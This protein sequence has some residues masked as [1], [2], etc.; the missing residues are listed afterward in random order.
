MRKAIVF[1]LLISVLWTVNVPVVEAASIAP[2]VS[3]SAGNTTTEFETDYTVKG[4]LGTAPLLPNST[5]EIIFPSSFSFGSMFVDHPGLT[6]TWSTTGTTVKFKTSQEILGGT[7]LTFEILGVINSN[8]PGTYTIEM[9]STLDAPGTP[10]EFSNPVTIEDAAS[11]GG[12]GELEDVLTCS[13]VVSCIKKVVK[14]I[15]NLPKF[16]INLLVIILQTIISLLIT[17]MIWIGASLIQFAINTNF[18]LVNHINDI[19]PTEAAKIGFDITLSLTN[20]GFVI[21]IIFIAFATILKMQNFAIRQA[22]PRL[23]IIAIL[24]NFSMFFA[25]AIINISNL[26][27]GGLTSIVIGGSPGSVPDYVGIFSQ[28]FNSSYTAVQIGNLSSIPGVPG[29]LSTLL[30]GGLNF[31][32]AA[33]SGFVSIISQ[34]LFGLLV[35]FTLIATAIMLVIR[36]IALSFLIMLLPLAL[37]T[38]I[39]PGLQIPGGG[40]PWKKWTENFT[41]W[42]IFFP[43]VMLFTA[44][45]LEVAGKLNN[46]GPYGTFQSLTNV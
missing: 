43:A 26:L 2:G 34:V 14:A 39:F 6:G 15:V 12:F 11:G 1:I 7:N 3:A 17:F 42:V 35:F 36:Y 37:L 33:I 9:R 32:E 25:T 44:I 19:P 45:A 41:K 27:G 21:A 13:G 18:Q 24:I 5:I 30:D 23:I 10:G 38:N 8:T 28:F 22:L 40:S 46:L 31:L 16:L 20:I 29:W 4:K